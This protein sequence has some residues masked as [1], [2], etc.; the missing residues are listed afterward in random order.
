M[1]SLDTGALHRQLQ[2]PPVS[3]ARLAALHDGAL[4]DLR[5]GGLPPPQGC[6]MTVAHPEVWWM[7]VLP[8]G[9]AG[10]PH[11]V[12][13]G[14]SVAMTVGHAGGTSEGHV[15]ATVCVARVMLFWGAK[16]NTHVVQHTCYAVHA[17]L[18][19]S[20]YVPPTHYT[21]QHTQHYTTP[22]TTLYNTSNTRYTGHLCMLHV[23]H[24]SSI[25]SWVVYLKTYMNHARFYLVM[26]VWV[27]M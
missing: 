21:T 15:A 8:G 10:V 4:W 14:S 9:V 22:C 2:G 1:P 27:V 12:V 17:P 6:L 23:G 25:H 24:C 19:V 16:C 26:L 7:T 11:R 5:G 18:I 3:F 20:V 13:W